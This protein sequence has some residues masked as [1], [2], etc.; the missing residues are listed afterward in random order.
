MVQVFS[1]LLMNAAQATGEGGLIVIRGRREDRL[2]TLEV[3]DDGPGIAPAHRSRVFDPFFT[4]KPEGTG[5][6][7]S[8]SHGIVNEHGGRIEVESKTHE[9]A[10]GGGRAGT[11]VR[12]I[13]PLTEAPA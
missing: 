6:G 8:I 2:L 7:L 9:E 4:T 5:L 13:L 10:L 12:V 11:T 3:E 1:N